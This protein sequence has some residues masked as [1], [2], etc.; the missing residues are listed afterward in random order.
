MKTITTTFLAFLLTLNWAFAQNKGE[1]SN[2][3]ISEF[4]NSMSIA[5][6]A[7]EDAF[8]SESGQKIQIIFNNNFNFSGYVISNEFKYADLRSM[9]IKSEN[10]PSALLQINRTVG[11]DHIVSYSGRIMNQKALEVIEIKKDM[12]DHYSLRK[13]GLDKI[14]QDCSY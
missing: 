12:A 3:K 8:K 6:S 1:L 5:K 4:P 13:I 11:K 2:E 9:I 14:L 10:D 7:L